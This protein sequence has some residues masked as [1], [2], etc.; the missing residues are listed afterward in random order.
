MEQNERSTNKYKVFI[1]TRNYEYETSEQNAAEHLHNISEEEWK[2]FIVNSIKTIDGYQYL[3]MIFHDKDKLEDGSPKGLHCHILIKFF[4]N[5]SFNS[6]KAEVNPYN[7][8][9]DNFEFAQSEGGSARY[10]IHITPAALQAQKYLYSIDDLIMFTRPNEN[11][12][13]EPKQLNLTETREYYSV[14]IS[15]DF[16]K[17]ETASKRQQREIDEFM[18][19]NVHIPLEKTIILP[20]DVPRILQTKFGDGWSQYHN[21]KIKKELLNKYE[22]GI[23]LKIN[24]METSRKCRKSNIYI[25]GKGGQG[26]SELAKSLAYYMLEKE[27]ISSSNLFR[28]SG[29]GKSNAVFSNYRN[30]HV[31]ILNEIGM[32]TFN[33]EQFCKTFDMHNFENTDNRFTNV[34]NTTRYTIF[35]KST[36]FY[37]FSKTIG[38]N[39][40]YEDKDD[41]NNKIAQVRRRFECI[42]NITDNEII[43]SRYQDDNGNGR[44]TILKTFDKPSLESIINSADDTKVILEEIYQA[45]QF[46]N[47]ID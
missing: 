42:V 44:P 8:R 35:T 12:D 40:H 32:D 46:Y 26:K 19:T 11:K 30:E 9:K 28:G 6:V 18:E 1:C 21:T 3:A 23:E 27:G 34:V 17:P 20:K 15:N 45:C 38:S 36:D 24:Q 4:N 7:D 16:E 14:L 25:H 33:Q 41:I 5:R 43:L 37:R 22:S 39:L 2:S 10:L 29:T 31:S 13:A 47:E